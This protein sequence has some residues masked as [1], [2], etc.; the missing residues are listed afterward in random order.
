[1]LGK[2]LSHFPKLSSLL[3]IGGNSPELDIKRFKENGWVSI[4]TFIWML[5]FP[6][7]SDCFCR[8]CLSVFDAVLC[9]SG[10]IIV[11][12]PGRLQDLLGRPHAVCEMARAVKALVRNTNTIGSYLVCIAN[13]KNTKIIVRLRVGYFGLGWSW[14]SPRHGIWKQVVTNKL[15]NVNQN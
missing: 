2:F 13:N 11:A 15:K 3:L 4:G 1:M 6:S 5:A 9:Y 8:C 14:S 12:T 7:W 10:N